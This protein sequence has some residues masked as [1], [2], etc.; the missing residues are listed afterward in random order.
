M[1]DDPGET[2][3]GMPLRRRPPQTFRLGDMVRIR[4]GPFAAFTGRIEGINHAKRLLK[5]EVEIFGRRTPIK[6]GY[7]DVEKISFSE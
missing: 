2:F 7:A 3:R 1:S 5:V 6:L 4:S